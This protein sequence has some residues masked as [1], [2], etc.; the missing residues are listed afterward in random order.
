MPM[1]LPG[2]R[3]Y[4]WRSASDV[5]ERRGRFTVAVDA[6]DHDAYQPCSCAALG[7]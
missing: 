1:R 6:A 5:D 3:R 7:P 4:T 2:V